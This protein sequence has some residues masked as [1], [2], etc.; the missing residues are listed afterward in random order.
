[1]GSHNNIKNA[2]SAREGKGG[3]GKKNKEKEGKTKV[4]ISIE[5]KWD[6]G[7]PQKRGERGTKEGVKN[8]VRRW[9]GKKQ[10]GRGGKGG[11]MHPS[12]RLK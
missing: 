3:G 9:K 6:P 10:K 12:M 4:I 11:E 1:M 2:S 7:P 8:S 5:R